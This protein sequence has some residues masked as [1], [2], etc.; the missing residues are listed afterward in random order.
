MAIR[1]RPKRGER[2]SSV[3]IRPRPKRGE[4]YSSVAIRLMRKAIR[5]RPKRGARPR[6]HSQ[7]SP[8]Y[9]RHAPAPPGRAAQRVPVGSRG[10]VVSACMLG[11]RSKEFHRVPSGPKSASGVVKRVSV[12]SKRR[13]WAADE[14]RRHN[15]DLAVPDEGGNQGTIRVHQGTIS[16]SAGCNK[17]H[18]AA[19]S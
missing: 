18:S 4:R 5:P 13:S 1:P 17:P 16:G 2:H 7:P 9:T 10:A 11:E 14:R 3:A 12:R 6:A 19:L 8:V 15:S